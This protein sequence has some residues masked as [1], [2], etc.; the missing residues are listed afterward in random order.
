MST[1]NKSYKSSKS[2]KSKSTKVPVKAGWSGVYNY[3]GEEQDIATVYAKL[4]VRVKKSDVLFDAKS[5]T[6][7]AVMTFTTKIHDDYITEL[8]EMERDAKEIAKKVGGPFTSWSF[9]SPFKTEQMI[10]TG[11]GVSDLLTLRIKLNEKTEMNVLDSAG[12]WEK[13]TDYPI[14]DYLVNGS[15]ADCLKMK[16][17][18][19][20]RKHRETG[21]VTAGMTATLES[22]L[23]TTLQ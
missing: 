5:F 7:G 6:E 3:K 16:L 20:S 2:S 10:S 22:F 19:Y 13:K 15:A 12:G 4:P 8:R 17:A 14:E 11:E 9:L 18:V 1:S 23:A 21:E